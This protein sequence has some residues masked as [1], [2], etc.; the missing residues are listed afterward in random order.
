[1]LVQIP[2][3]LLAV[4]KEMIVHTFRVDRHLSSH[5][6]KA[7]TSLPT[8]RRLDLVGAPDL[9]NQC[10]LLCQEVQWIVRMGALHKTSHGH[11][12]IKT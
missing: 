3:S 7:V 2:P 10:S 11:H 6:R 8:T 9:L 5:I 4:T 12:V 1:M